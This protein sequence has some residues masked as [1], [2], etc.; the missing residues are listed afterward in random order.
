MTATEIRARLAVLAAELSALHEAEQ[1]AAATLA[2]ARLALEAISAECWA[3]SGRGNWQAA[4]D[5][6]AEAERAYQV[7]ARA[8]E[9]NLRRA[10]LLRRMVEPAR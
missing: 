4:A 8:L 3:K 7:A 9:E 5:A 1:G 2:V 6:Y 10:G